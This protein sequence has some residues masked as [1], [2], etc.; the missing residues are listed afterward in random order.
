M[1]SGKYLKRAVAKHG[2]E[3]FE[4]EILEFFQDTPSMLAAEAEVVTRDFIKESSNYNLAEGGKG[5]FRGDDCYNSSQ[6]S[7]KISAAHQ[8]TT[9][10]VDSNG[11]KFRVDCTDY[12]LTNGELA[13]HTKGLATM[14][15]SFGN[16]VKVPKDD[17]KIKS[18]ELVGVTKGLATVKDSLGNVFKVP[19]DDPKLKSGELVGVTKGHTQTPESNA[20]RSESQKGI[21]KPQLFAS[22]IMCRKSTSI[23]N[24]IRWHHTRCF[25][26]K[27]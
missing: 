15:D 23:A 19:K 14:K 10:V 18:G 7:E 1:G 4:K 3:N 20:K 9:S 25:Q 22:C 26:N 24:L 16:T 8:G 5:G 11:K 2:V 17:L 13:G 21:S 6:R 27:I 12:R